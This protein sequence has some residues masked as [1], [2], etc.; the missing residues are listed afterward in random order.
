MTQIRRWV[1]WLGAA[2]AIALLLLVAGWASSAVAPLLVFQTNVHGL[3]IADYHGGEQALAPLSQQV[4]DDANRDAMTTPGPSI[5]PS[6]TALPE[7]QPIVPSPLPSKQ[8]PD[9]TPTPPPLITTLQT[10]TITGAVQD[11]Q[12]AVG[13]TNALVSLSPGGLATIT[14]STGAFSF[15]SVP[16]GTYS[17][18]ASAS[19]Y[20]T[21]SASVTVTA[22]HNVN[23][24]LHLL[25][26]VAS[27]SIQGVV[28]N[29]ATGKAV[30]GAMVTL[31]PGMLATVSDSTGYYGFPSVT[32]GTYTLTVS[33]FGF[34]SDIQTITVASGHTVKTNV[35]LMPL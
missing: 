3:A 31:T 17:I 13:I 28:K 7:P 27:G 1:L 4:I 10:G 5:S 18:T 23:L 29:V 11:S 16:A 33:A 9:P 12:T 8:I 21:A 15:A 35:S 14:S 22:G 19:G 6:S 20:Q 24:N 32:P 26:T 30:A 25:S 2:V 34:Q